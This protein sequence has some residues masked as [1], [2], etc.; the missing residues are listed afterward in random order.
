MHWIRT[1]MRQRASKVAKPPAELPGCLLAISYLKTVG[2]TNRTCGAYV[3]GVRWH[4]GEAPARL[5]CSALKLL[6]LSHFWAMF[7]RYAGPP[8]GLLPDRCHP[9][10][11]KVVVAEG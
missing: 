8:T 6:R 2:Y 11:Q 4:P 3:E 5:P 10:G 9:R 7:G 1:L